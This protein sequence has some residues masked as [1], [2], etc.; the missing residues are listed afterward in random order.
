MK[1]KRSCRRSRRMKGLH[2]IT[3]VI[4]E[5]TETHEELAS[6]NNCF[7]MLPF[8]ILT[9]YNT[10]CRIKHQFG[11]EG[12]MEEI[13][14][15]IVV[16][17]YLMWGLRESH[18]DILRATFQSWPIGCL[19]VLLL[20]SRNCHCSFLCAMDL[21]GRSGYNNRVLLSCILWKKY[22]VWQFWKICYDNFQFIWE[23][24]NFYHRFVVKL[25]LNIFKK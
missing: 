20:L 4:Y 5:F 11:V 7:A 12:L 9:Q 3:F 19:C 16:N 6:K 8:L 2:W 22:F 1:G 13:K 14:K 23:G 24:Y 18:P 25:S 17:N 21:H 10:S 15:E